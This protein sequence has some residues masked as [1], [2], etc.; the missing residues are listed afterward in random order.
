MSLRD[1]RLGII[2]EI[3]FIFLIVGCSTQKNTPS[4]RSYHELTTRYNVFFNA[5]ESYNETLNATYESHKDN[6]SSILPLYPNSSN[7]NDTTQKVLGGQFTRVVDKTTKAIQ[8]HSISAKPKREREKMNRQQYRDWLRQNEFNPFIDKAWILMGKAHVQNGDYMEAISVFANTIRLFSYDLDVVSEAQ[9]WLVRAYAEIG[10]YMDAELLVE[11]LIARKISGNLQHDF[12]CAHANLLLKQKQYEEAIPLLE[13]AIAGERNSSQRRRMQFL[14]GQIYAHLGKNNEAYL[15]FDK[16]KGINTPYDVTLNVMLA[17]SRVANDLKQIIDALMRQTKRANNEQNLD[18]IYGAIGDYYL[19]HADTTSAI[20]NYLNAESKSIS[21]GVDKALVQEKLG[22]IYYLNKDYVSSGERYNEAA[23]IF[24]PS[25]IKYKEVLHRAEVLG[26]LVPHI[27]KLRMQDSLLHLANLPR[28]EQLKIINNHIVHLKQMEKGESTRAIVEELVKS[29]PTTEMP[30]L[31]QNGTKGVFYFYNPQL[32]ARGVTEF[33][34]RW[35]NRTLVD[36]WRLSNNNTIGTNQNFDIND[37]Y[38]EI[39]TSSST[40]Q[41]IIFMPEYWLGQLPTSPEAV[42][43]SKKIIESSLF[44]IGNIAKNRLN[45]VDLAINSYTR[46]CD[47]FPRSEFAIDAIYNMYMIYRQANDVNMAS[48]YRNRIVSDY[49]DSDFA[50]MLTD[51]EYEAVMTNFAKMEDALYQGTYKFYR[52]GDYGSVQQSYEKATRLFRDGRLMPKFS[53]LNA[54][55]YA[56]M[57][58]NESLKSSLEK[59]VSSFPESDES[60]F[61]QSVLEGLTQGRELVANANVMSDMGWV[62]G[63]ITSTSE[64]EIIE[65]STEFVNDKEQPH[66]LLLLFDDKRQSRNELLF[67]VANHNFS[68]Y[69]LRSFSTSFVKIGGVNAMSIK[70]FNSYDE[71]KLYTTRI[72]SDEQLREIIVDSLTTLVVSDANLALLWSSKSV[73]QYIEHMSSAHGTI[74]SENKK[75]DAESNIEHT[76]DTFVPLDEKENNIE[77]KKDI[78]E[79]ADETPI[80]RPRVNE[81]VKPVTIEE[82]LQELERRQQQAMSQSEQPMSDSERKKQLRE[83]EKERKELLKQRQREIKA[84]EKERNLELK[85]REKEREQKIKEQEIIRKAKLQERERI[86]RE[87]KR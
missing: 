29:N 14:L 46:L 62:S 24:P 55:S 2:W 74:Y 18:K 82:K 28:E 86:L 17:Q 38:A 6:W 45:D 47:D 54:L 7:D 11:G 10:W 61:A 59:L 80:H 60:T 31:S 21:K 69:L 83:R 64:G 33:K 67:A 26:E 32:V 5:E 13:T 68:T 57:G 73:E 4:S 43:A 40:E 85:R 72:S 79:E 37:A 78:S 48:V 36:N 41:K 50:E 52:D 71:A 20:E 84:K 56:I 75:D 30:T 81:D 34:K 51:P 25:H 58:D 12:A 19:L 27:K 44:A 42:D 8:E 70:T 16:L 49:P 22:W 65:Y 76:I 87:Q 53:L 3:L 15:A 35:G 23:T 63:V 77:D 66:S 9:I 39:V 1:R